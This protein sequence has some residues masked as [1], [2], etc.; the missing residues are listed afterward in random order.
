M[1]EPMSVAVQ[2]VEK[3]N[4]IIGSKVAIF[5]GGGIGLLMAQLVKMAGASS[6]TV[7]ERLKRNAGSLWKTAQIMLLIL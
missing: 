7:I 6:V 5:G 3:A 4:I 1:T 2:A